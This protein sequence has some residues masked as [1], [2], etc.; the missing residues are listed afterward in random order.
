MILRRPTDATLATPI[1]DQ[2]PSP[3]QA[4]LDAVAGCVSVS[5][6]GGLEKQRMSD[7]IGLIAI[8]FLAMLGG[9]LTAYI[10]ELGNVLGGQSSPASYGEP[11][12]RR[13]RDGPCCSRCGCLTKRQRSR[14]TSS[15]H[16]RSYDSPTR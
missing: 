4:G 12:Y 15:L 1:H 10:G 11:P 14:V 13:G 3:H 9:F 2:V 5:T 7:L 8:C 16:S 6:C